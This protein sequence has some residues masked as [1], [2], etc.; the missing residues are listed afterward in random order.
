LAVESALCSLQA[1]VAQMA[2]AVVCFHVL[3]HAGV[4]LLDVVGCVPVELAPAASASVFPG[5]SLLWNCCWL[6]PLAVEWWAG[7][8]RVTVLETAAALL[9]MG[10]PVLQ[11]ALRP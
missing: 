9:V 10:Q 5:Q 1:V 2:A 6:M 4:G 11:E 7:S 3:G 8:S